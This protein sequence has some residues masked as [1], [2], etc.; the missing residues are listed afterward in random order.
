MVAGSVGVVFGSG[1]EPGEVVQDGH[2]TGDEKETWGDGVESGPTT[3]V[4]K[5]R[6]TVPERDV[7]S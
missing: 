3:G 2:T 7:G 4:G 1:V 6:S 5:S